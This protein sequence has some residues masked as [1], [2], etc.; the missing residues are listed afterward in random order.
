LRDWLEDTLLDKR[1]L[2]RG[3]FNE[4]FLRHMIAEHMSGR[5][6]YAIQFGL[7]LTFELWNRLF[8]ED[9]PV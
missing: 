6:N 8:I 4:A 5:R 2:D 1:A 7:L 3:Y 9:E